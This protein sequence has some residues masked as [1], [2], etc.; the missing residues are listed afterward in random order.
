MA[1]L[2]YTESNRIQ[3]ILAVDR[4][5]PSDNATRDKQPKFFRQV[6]AMPVKASVCCIECPPGGCAQMIRSAQ[7][8]S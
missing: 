3:Y 4:L 1:L 8:I 7:T 6:F 5:K 2:R